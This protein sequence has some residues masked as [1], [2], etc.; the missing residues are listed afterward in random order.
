M[1]LAA[2][3]TEPGARHPTRRDIEA[4]LRAH[5]CRCTGWQSIVEAAEDA[6]GLTDA[7]AFDEAQRDP[8]LAAWRA[9]VEGPYAQ[10][11]GPD[12]V[13]GGGGFADDASPPG[14]LVQLGAETPLAS[15]VR[16]ARA[17]A[18]RVQGRNSTVALSQPV[19]LP[20]GDWALTLQTTWVEPA[21]V[22]PDASWSPPGGPPAS[23]LANGGAFG[24][25]RHSPVPAHAVALAD[26]H[27]EVVRVLW[28]R[29][30]VVRRGP[31]RPPLAVALRP[32]GTGVVRLGRSPGS[33]DLAPLEARLH[34]LRPGLVVEEVEVTGPPVGPELRGRLGRG[35]GRA[36]CAGHA[37]GVGWNGT[38]PRTGARSRERPRR[39]P[40]G[41][42]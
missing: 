5:L 28:R 38:R 36:A 17:E 25:K 1:R 37:A 6:L 19:E 4:G 35:A 41:R 2:L 8:I 23:P 27:G 9:Q 20:E 42:R 11:S 22:E 33:A 30:D 40:F 34:E 10:T 29:E 26:E 16:A 3:G 15:S 32:D 12:V 21:Y 14:S 18:G 13:L 7:T 39:A 24:G 31:K